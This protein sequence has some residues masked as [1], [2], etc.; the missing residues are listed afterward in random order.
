MR[1]VS[2]YGKSFV[3]IRFRRRRFHP[4]DGGLKGESLS[5]MFV[6]LRNCGNFLD[7]AVVVVVVVPV[8]GDATAL[9]PEVAKR[10]GRRRRRRRRKWWLR[11]ISIDSDTIKERSDLRPR[12]MREKRRERAVDFGSC[13]G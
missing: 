10:R 9:M 5:S 3:S 2:S 8:D 12:E 6:F 4:E 13:L 1:F 11:Q 7:K